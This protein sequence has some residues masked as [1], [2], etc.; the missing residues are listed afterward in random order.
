MSSYLQ[1]SAGRLIQRRLQRRTAS[2]LRARID[3]LRQ[4]LAR[5]R[6]AGA[7][8]RRTSGRISPMER[9]MLRSAVH[10]N[11]S[12]FAQVNLQ[13]LLAAGIH[14]HTDRVET[15]LLRVREPPLPA[16]RQV[17]RMLVTQRVLRE[18]L[19][20]RP[21]M[22]AAPAA[23]PRAAMVTRVQQRN[24]FPQ[25][26]LTM[27]RS[28]PAAAT[29]ARA[30]SDAHRSRRSRCAADAGSC[31]WRSRRGGAAAVAAAGV[32]APDRPRD[33]P[34]RPARAVLAGTHR[35]RVMP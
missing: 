22:V 34:A 8:G 17:D 13:A 33:P 5:Q 6:P 15:A 20:Q 1:H 23:R 18:L 27:V 30:A 19:V 16:M 14:R 31:P 3:A 12:F 24:V 2:T 10:L 32:V 21:T 29:T 11:R 4:R 7:L 35:P 9:V 28:L 26:Q 25:V